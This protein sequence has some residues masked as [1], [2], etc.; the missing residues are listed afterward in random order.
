MFTKQEQQRWMKIQF[1]RGHTGN[2]RHE[3]LFEVSGK[4][5]RKRGKRGSAGT[6]YC[7]WRAVQTVCHAVWRTVGPRI[8]ELGEEIELSHTAVLHILKSRPTMR[9][10]ASRWILHNFTEVRRWIPYDAAQTHLER[11]GLMK[12]LS[13][14]VL[15]WLLRQGPDHTNLILSANPMGSIITYHHTNK[16]SPYS[17][18][19]MLKLLWFLWTSVMLSS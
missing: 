15:L 14:P 5:T 10:I 3:N 19:I 1:A 12:T 6:P 2:Q 13:Y 7:Q 4:M 16:C 11:Y 9:K 8:R 18:Y 17:Y